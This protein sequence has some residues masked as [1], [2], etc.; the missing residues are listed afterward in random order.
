MPAAPSPPRDTLTNSAATALSTAVVTGAAAIVGALV[1]REFGRNDA[2]DGF[3]A[4]YGVYLVLVLVATSL[5]VVVVPRLVRARAEGRFG[6][7]LTRYAVAL[8]LVCA[9]VVAVTFLV[10]GFLGGL[11]TATSPAEATAVEA[12]RWL[13]PA[14]VAQIFAGLA[15]SALAAWDDY[16][17]A[18]SGFAA[19]A[20]AGLVL[21]LLRLDTGITSLGE[22]LALN[23]A[24]SLA[25]P[26]V[27]LWRRRLPWRLPRPL[28]VGDRLLEF[29]R[30][31]GVPLAVQGLLLIALRSAAEVGV[32]QQTSFSYAYLIASSVVAVTAAS[33]SLVTVAPLTRL[34]L[35]P[36]RIARHVAS[37]TWLSLL[38]IL[39][40]AVVLAA[41]G[42]PLLAAAL[43]P[44]FAGEAGRE[45]GLLVLAL[46]P[47]MAASAAVAIV[48]PLLFVA[49]RVRAL[50]VVAVATVV[51]HVPVDAAGRALGGIVGIALAFALTTV[52]V[53]V[54]LLA[55]LT[56]V[57][58]RLVLSALARP[59]LR[60]AW[61]YAR[62]LR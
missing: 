18:A 45:T 13:V 41:A 61:T 4:A 16:F 25:V 33:F 35:T 8:A 26:A 5:R 47:W 30:G 3:F 23:G 50:P 21:I 60:E 9:P 12:L 14:A 53:F 48:V 52:L 19:G 28:R 62:T 58:P 42:E 44:A 11:L 2:T 10:T 7:D 22:G 38:P 55:L 54:A 56:P 57:A 39:A 40:V 1:A 24:V 49:G 51:V 15:A 34:G 17:V 43:G 29:A 37:L 59:R 31:I 46:A 32:G 27:A 20:C 36:E 6:E